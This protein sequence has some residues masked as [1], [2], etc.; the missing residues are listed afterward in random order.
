MPI[1]VMRTKSVRKPRIKRTYR[2]KLSV[3]LSVKSYVN[4]TIKRNEETKMSSV[5]YTLANFNSSIASTADLITLLPQVGVGVNQNNRIGNAIRPIKMVITGYVVYNSPAVALNSDARLLGARL[6]CFQDK[7]T[8]SYANNIY[9][10]NLLNL[11]G[12]SATFAGSPLDWCSPHNSETFIWYADKKM[13]IM[14]PY[15]YTNNTL[16]GSTNAITGMDNSLFHPFTITLTQKQ[17][18]AV[19]KYD[20][21]DSLSYPTNFAPYIGLG[22]AD[23][24]N[25]SPDITTTQLAMTFNCTLYFKDA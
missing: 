25:N 19:L 13:R 17:L 16:P 20:Q 15:G 12:T 18:P 1:K 11:G 21:G 8:R 10:Y 9:N 2:K 3:P 23:L 22:Y 24:L 6:F 14:K 7:T 5:Q 4:K